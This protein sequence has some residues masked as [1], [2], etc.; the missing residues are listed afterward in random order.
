MKDVYKF[1]F[2]ISRSI[3]ASINCIVYKIIIYARLRFNITIELVTTEE[4]LKS[5]LSENTYAVS[6]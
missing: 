1:G 6:V 5:S 4:S 2:T 3:A